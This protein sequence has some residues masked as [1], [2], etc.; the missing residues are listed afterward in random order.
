MT[1]PGSE[2]LSYNASTLPASIAGSSADTGGS[3]TVNSVQI[4][5]QEGLSNYWGGATFNQ[6]SIFYNATGGTTGAWTY[7]TGTLVGQLT[8]ARTYTITAKATDAA[9][10]T[11]TT[12]R[13]FSYDTSAPTVT[14]VSSTKLNG[15]YPSGTSI[16][17]TVTFNE[18]VTVTGS[19]TLAL[20]SGGSA[21]YSSGNGSPTLTFSYTVGAGDNSADLDYSATNSLSLSGGTIKDAATNNATLTLPTVGGANSI[22]GQKNIVVDTNNPTASVTTPAVDG[23]TYNATSLPANLA[24]SSADTGGSST[25]S[26]VQVAIQDG[27]GNYWGG[28][29]FNQASISYNATGGTTAAWTY[30]TATLA[31]QLTNGHTYTIT[32]RSTDPAGNTGTTTRTLVY[33]TTAPT[34]TNVTSTKADGAYPA[35]TLIPVTVTFSENVTVTGSPTLALNSGGTATYSSGSGG[36]T[37]TFNYTVGAGDNSADLDYPATNSLALSGGT[38]KDAAT[39]NAT[40][41]LPAVGGANSIGGQKNIVIDTNTP[42]VSSVSSSNADGAYRAGQTIH[43]D[44]TFSKAVTLAGGTP[45]LDLNTTPTRAATYASGSGGTTYTFDY[46]VQAGDTSARLD[47]ASA[48]AL[49][50]NGA[51]IRDIASTDA[52]TTL[53]TGIGTT[54]ALANSKN[55]VVDTAAPIVTNV[56]STPTTASYKAGQ[57]VSITVSFSEAVIVTGNPTLALNTGQVATYASGSGAGSLTFDYIVQ[58]GDNASPLAY[59][60]TG[61]LALAGGTIRD[62]AANN[63][64]LT[65]A[66]PGTGGSLDAN[67]AITVDTTAPTVAGLSAS[68]AD[69][70][71]KAG[72]IIHVLAGFGEPV[73]VTGT[74]TLALS[75]GG[76]ATYAS[77]SGSSTLTLDYTVQPGDTAARLDA[78]STGALGGG[79]IRDGAGNDA[80]LTVAIGQGTAGA[81]ANAKNIRIDTTNPT[82]TISSP[83]SNGTTY[84]SS[85]LPASIA[86]S[87]ADAGG[88]GVANVAVAIQDGSGNYWNGTTFGSASITYNPTGGTTAAWTYSTSTLVAQL[89]DGHTYTISAQA[90][91]SAGNQ[92]TTTRTFVFDVTA[93]AVTSVS[94]TN[95]NGAYKAGDTIHVQLT[96]SKTVTVTGTPK[97]TLNTTPSRTADFTSGSGT[98]TLTFDYTVQ[99]GDNV[100]VLDYASTA[101]LALNAGTIRDASTNDASL[102]LPAT[103]GPGSLSANKSLQIDTTAAT[104][105]SVSASNADGPYKAGDTIHVQITFSEAVTVTGSP[106][107]TLNTAPAEAAT[108]VSG[109]GTATLTFDY[110]VQAGDTSVDL[111]YATVASLTLNG[112]TIRDAASNDATLTLPTVG[113]V[114]SLAGQKNI[115]IDTSAPTVTSLTVSGTTLDVTYSEPLA[116][117]PSTSDF[118]ATLN[119]LG[120]TVDSASIVSSNIVHLTLHDAAHH[121][122]AVVLTYSG[123]SVTDLVGNAAA[124]YSGQSAT[125]LT[126][127]AN[128]AA[129]TLSTPND[130]VFINST[131]PTLSAGFADPDTLDFG[132]VTFQVCTDSSCSTSLGTFDSTTTNLNVG[133]NGSATVPGGFNLQTATQYWWRAKSVD[134]SNASSPFSATRTFTVDTTAPSVSASA[135]PGAGAGYQYYDG[136]AKTLWL[137]ADQAGDFSLAANASDAQSGIASVDFP[138]IFG[139]SAN[140][141]PS[142]P[143]QSSTYSFDGTGTPFGSPGA[144]TVTASNGVTV[145]APNTTS[146]Q[147]TIS[148]DGTAPAAFGL[149][150]PADTAKIGTGI[151]VS[152]APTDAGSGMRQVTFFYCDASGGPCVPSIQIGS[153]QTLPAAGIYA[154]TWDTTGLTDGHD[155]AVEAVATDNVG[156]TRASAV[157]T[158][159]VDNSAP[160]VSVAAPVAVTGNAFQWYDA[161]GKKLWLNDHQSG[162]FKLRV[163][164]SDPHSGISSVTFPALLGSSSN[165]G[166]LNG[167]VYDSTTTYL[168]NSPAAPGV[169]AI[170]AANGVTIPAP[171]TNSDS[172]DVEVD[173]AAPATNPTFPLNNGSY[174]PGTWNGVC[175]P[176]GICGTVTDLS[177]SGVA[178]VNVSIKDR[179]T[180]KYWGGSAFD[181]ASQT[182]NTATLAGANWHYP[183]DESQLTSP[184]SYLVEIYS[185]DNVGNSEVHQQIRFTYGNDVG[186]PT[187]TLTLSAGSHA[188]LTAIAPYV[189]YYG[190]TNGGGSFTLQQSATDPSGVDT[191]TFPDLSSTSGFSGTGGT[192]TNGSAADPFVAT[193]AYSFTSGATAAPGAKNVDSA[194]LRGNPTHDQVTFV[195]DNTAPSGGSLTVNGGSVYST[196]ANFNVAHVDYTDNLGGSGLLSS[197]LTVA[198]A[199]LSNG[200]CGS[201]GVAGR[202]SRRRCSPA[203]RAPATGSRSPAPTTSA[204]SRR[205]RSTRRS[206]RPRRA[207]P[208]SPSATSRA[209]TRTTTAPARSTTGRRQAARSASTE[210]RPTPS[211]ACR[212]TR[213]RRSPAS[214]ARA[215]PGAR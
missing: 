133:Q 46:T 116:G 82:E 105:S 9:G 32:A 122:D 101:A 12:T 44:V 214:R 89:A 34:V 66:T 86:G 192:S 17:I 187:T 78:A 152:A 76:T 114:S 4:A 196:A 88:S 155:Y 175:T 35:G 42:V 19:P 50:L 131:T 85:S 51:T 45:T 75:S 168:F 138:S 182:F 183:L 146:D 53:P 204:T 107:L 10:N 41:T 144:V 71:Y 95:P 141:D 130:G 74:P 67:T 150:G 57:T 108:Y 60:G 147:V 3:S 143:Y 197:V 103:G 80:T 176:S 59:N 110:T 184:H 199:T 113:G 37:L 56:T 115:V 30:S 94:A 83:A 118:A 31:G 29:T 126:P 215:R 190:T 1:A 171:E 172:I 202:G 161:A 174:G 64:S 111:D 91:D 97:L 179:T 156:H 5:I 54:G 58:P 65:L 203:R 48:N 137:N 206:T 186:G 145:P 195:L 213:S 166:V 169:K 173:G 180:G 49:H 191:I 165:A 185:V 62:A 124:T 170:S 120:D 73:T 96:F 134:S 189:L 13:T 177:G 72:D 26:S 40:L 132:K 162:S 52:V 79:T 15:A 77:G 128:P 153:A 167:G 24:G 16:P 23:N 70:A 198:S 47:A 164:A 39:N 104:V 93:P 22:G 81:L 181:Q 43:V 21:T 33:D 68:N 109:S 92:S 100:A 99:A 194:D 106:K 205:P 125:N 90:T 207:S 157:S 117:S 151:T 210:P 28:A 98:N 8:D 129:A 102:V 140:N 119:G 208:S 87:S 211:R 63:A 7:G 25:V 149:G 14:N 148:A 69:G 38:I 112:G 123:S 200:T 159:M 18:A 178:Q 55:I 142:N 188:F 209:A 61:S 201:F 6:A 121:L 163:N 160:S 27:A 193:S 84:N 158:V 135:A 154:V 2:G 20:N 127:N 212:A 36:A 136:A 139:T 11:S